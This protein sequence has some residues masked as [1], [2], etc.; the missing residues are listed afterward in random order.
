MHRILFHSLFILL[1]FPSFLFV[2]WFVESFIIYFSLFISVRLSLSLYFLPFFFFFCT[3]SFSL[4]LFLSTALCPS[5][6]VH[7]F[8]SS[9]VL[10]TP[11]S[12]DSVL[13]FIPGC[14][15]PLP[16]SL[17][18]SLSPSL[19]PPIFLLSSFPFLQT[20]LLE[21]FQANLYSLCACALT[22]KSLENVARGCFAQGF[23]SSKQ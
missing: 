2:R 13:L 1:P 15:P 8:V 22:L 20:F 12:D 10:P 19:S 3:D 6:P 21:V 9:F 7:S 23:L 17:S 16:L 5:I 11:L 4:H 18:L 14:L